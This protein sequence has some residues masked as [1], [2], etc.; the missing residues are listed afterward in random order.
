M[1]EL[2]CSGAVEPIDG[3]NDGTDELEENDKIEIN[4]Q[5]INLLL[6][7]LLGGVTF[8]EGLLFLDAGVHAIDHLLHR[9]RVSAWMHGHHS[10]VTRVVGERLDGHRPEPVIRI[11]VLEDL[12]NG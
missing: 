5:S 4:P 2:E 1:R 11:N 9:A 3:R 12:G 7:V 8:S 10:Q 6:L